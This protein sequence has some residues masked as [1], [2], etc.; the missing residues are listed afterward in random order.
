MKFSM[1]IMYTLILLVACFI[2]AYMMSWITGEINYSVILGGLFGALLLFMYTIIGESKKRKNVSAYDERSIRIVTNYV[3]IIAPIL[4]VLGNITL[5]VLLF[6]DITYIKTENLFV[7][8]MISLII[9]GIGG[10]IVNKI[11]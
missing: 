3:A 5:I 7:F 10:F 6:F 11:F 8:P 4:F 2:G 1:K 9:I